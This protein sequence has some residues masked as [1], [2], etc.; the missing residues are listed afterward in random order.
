MDKTGIAIFVEKKC[1]QQYEA[2]IGT[3]INLKTNFLGS[4]KNWDHFFKLIT[5]VENNK[6]ASIIM[7]DFFSN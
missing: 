5:H 1:S 3:I 2:N 6:S 7:M 4:Y